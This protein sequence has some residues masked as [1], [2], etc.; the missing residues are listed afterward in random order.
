MNATPI[1]ASGQDLD[2]HAN[3]FDESN[4]ITLHKAAD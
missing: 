3:L 1:Q 2:K 4:R